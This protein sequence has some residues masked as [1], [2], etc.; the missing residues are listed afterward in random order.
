MFLLSWV[1]SGLATDISPVQVVL[2]IISIYLFMALQLSVEPWPLFSVSES[3]MQSVGLLRRGISPSQGR[4]LQTE[5]HKHRINAT[6]IRSLSGIRTHD[7]SIEAGE[8]G[9]YLRPRSHRDRHQL[10]LIS[11]LVLNGNSPENLTRQIMRK[12]G[13]RHVEMNVGEMW[14]C[15][16]PHNGVQWESVVSTGMYR[17]CTWKQENFV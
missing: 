4:Y 6:D 14:I 16:L 8:D 3:Y 2:P 9:S 5:Q 13:M 12:R 11:D 15:E 17:R 7:P 10:F 1:I